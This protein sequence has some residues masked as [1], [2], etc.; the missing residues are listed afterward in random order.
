M[1][2]A[3]EPSPL[4]VSCWPAVIPV[5]VMAPVERSEVM[6]VAPPKLPRAI[7]WAAPDTLRT[8]I[9]SIPETVAAGTLFAVNPESVKVRVS[10]VAEVPVSV[11]N[12]WNSPPVSDATP[13]KFVAVAVSTPVVSVLVKY[14]KTP[15]NIWVKIPVANFLFHNIY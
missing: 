12:A 14:T 3:A 5:T 1:L 10:V 15:C 9:F 7:V 4:I 13:T 11:S 6:D 2:F 8:I